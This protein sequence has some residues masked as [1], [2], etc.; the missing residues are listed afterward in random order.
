MITRRNRSWVL[1]RR[2]AGRTRRRTCMA[3]VKNG[4]A[5]VEADVR[6]GTAYFEWSAPDDADPSDEAVWLECM[7]AVHRPECAA[8]CNRHTIQLASIRA[9]YQKAVRENKLADFRRAYLNQ[10]RPK[11]KQAEET[12]VGNWLACA[13][14]LAEFTPAAL[15]VAISFDRDF[16]SLGVFGHIADGREF[17]GAQDRV[18]LTGDEDETTDHL[19]REAARIGQDYD[20][21]VG[22]VNS[23]Q[24]QGFGAKIVAAG[25][26]RIAAGLTTRPVRLFEAKFPDYVVACADIV[27][28]VAARKVAHMNHPELNEA[29]LGSRW[30]SA[31]DGGRVFARK[32]SE[33][34]VSMLEAVTV[35]RKAA[36]MTGGA[37]EPWAVF[38]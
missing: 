5:S 33:T 21:P 14:E 32:T 30:R 38:L 7:P 17:V 35:A 28:Q 16:G 9:V 13:T 12:A 31:G 18:A 27:D 34:D 22:V 1:S 25:E 24:T 19:A 20:I 8:D 37:E 10:W 3:K 6:R 15:G 4:R 2:P 11:P 36:E 26:A 29:V 23:G